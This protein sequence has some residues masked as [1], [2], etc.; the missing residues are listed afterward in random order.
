VFQPVEALGLNGWRGLAGL[1]PRLK[2]MRLTTLR[3]RW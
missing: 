2:I 1:D 3:Y